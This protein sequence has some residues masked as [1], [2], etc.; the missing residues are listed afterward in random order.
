MNWSDK[1]FAYCERGNDPGFWAEPLNAL[2]NAGFIVAAVVALARWR[3]A[4]GGKVELVLIAMVFA[5]G[6]GSFLFHTIASRWARI[7]DV[8]P[9]GLFMFG[10]LAYA[11]SRFAGLEWR[12]VAASLLLFLAS[13]AV[14]GSLDC[15]GAPCLNGSLGYVPTLAALLVVGLVMTRRGGGTGR[16]LLVAAGIF[17]ISLALRSVDK[18]LCPAVLIGPGWRAGTHALWHILNALV[19]YLLLIAAMRHGKALRNGEKVIAE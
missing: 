1:V 12:G 11:L 17:A 6:I 15:G 4:R 13:G 2:S 8:A 5:I 18:S 3:G 7:A 16:S 10:Y 14:A 9:I 19:L